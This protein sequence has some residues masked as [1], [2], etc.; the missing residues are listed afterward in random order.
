M[1]FEVAKNRFYQNLRL[2][3]ESISKSLESEEMQETLSNTTKDNGK[4]L[5]KKSNNN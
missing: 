3:I 4:K 2:R 5:I 1:L